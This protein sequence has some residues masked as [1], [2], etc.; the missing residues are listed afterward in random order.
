MYKHFC[1]SE[2]IVDALKL[3]YIPKFLQK[4][5]I[6]YKEKITNVSQDVF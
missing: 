1:Q 6:H 3:K 5:K 2:F 4:K